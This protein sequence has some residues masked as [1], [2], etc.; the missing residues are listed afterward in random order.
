MLTINN[1]TYRIQGRELFDDASLVLPDGAKAGFVG[2][3]G[4][5]KTTLFHIIQSHI[6][7]DAGSFE[8]NKKAKLGAVAQEAPAGDETVLDVVLAADKERTA[9]M[10]LHPPGRHRS[11]HR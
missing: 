9:L 2:K 7:A 10:D 5:G 3:N 1:L 4:T 6:N 8:I 11:A